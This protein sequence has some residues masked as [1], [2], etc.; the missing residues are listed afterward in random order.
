VAGPSEVTE[1]ISRSSFFAELDADVIDQVGERVRMITACGGER[2][3]SRGGDPD[4]VYVLIRGRLRVT[5]PV[6]GGGSTWIDLGPGEAVGE[7]GVL[8]GHPRSADVDAVRDCEIAVLDRTSFDELFMTSASASLGL[9]RHVARL[10]ATEQRPRRA[11]PVSVVALVDGGSGDVDRV[12]QEI[13]SRRSHVTVI[14]SDGHGDRPAAE[15]IAAAD[16]PDALVVISCT[17][18]EPAWERDAL[19]QADL[20][21]VVTRPTGPVSPAARAACSELAGAH[22]PPMI[23]LV[24]LHPAGTRPRGTARRLDELRATRAHHLL[25]DGDGWDR[26]VRRIAG[27]EVGIALSGGGARAMA[28]LGAMRSLV[29]AGMPV[30]LLGGNSIGGLVAGVLAT[31]GPVLDAD[32]VDAA[33]DLLRREMQALKLGR[34]FDAPVL[35]LLSVRRVEPALE[36][37][38]DGADLTDGW[39]SVFVMTADLTSCAP[40]VVDRGPVALWVRATST[41]PG[42]WPPVVD[43]LGHLHV[44]GALF[45]N[46]PIEPLA[47]RGA[48]RIVA[49]NVSNRV[50]FRVESGSPQVTSPWELFR[51]RRSSGAARDFPALGSVLGRSGVVTSLVGQQRAASLAD[52]VIEPDVSGIALSDYRAFEKAVASGADA[53]ERWLDLNDIGEWTAAGAGER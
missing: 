34:R 1:V 21:L 37:I 4:G 26:L 15:V 18:R 52:V 13:A 19:R 12:S 24:T 46:L 16:Q 22:A 29:A 33:I 10:F 2:V 38:F 8:T 39:R 36:R 14:D 50:D 49:V 27:R 9:A 35:S 48:E 51:Q 43:D 25:G 11:S 3:L 6:E 32:T 45:D 7:L 41:V 53:A 17:G 42:L 40:A 28:H 30:D 44:D 5:R 47:A 20:V 31:A 23:E